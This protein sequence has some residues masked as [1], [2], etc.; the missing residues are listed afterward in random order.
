MGFRQKETRFEQRQKI[1]VEP[2]FFGTGLI[3]SANK[4]CT[5]SPGPPPVVGFALLGDG[6]ERRDDD[7]PGVDPI[8]PIASSVSKLII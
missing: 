5:P 4:L 2:L 3:F 6:G 8:G 1:T 7:P